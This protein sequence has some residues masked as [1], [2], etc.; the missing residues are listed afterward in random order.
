LG[1]SQGKNSAVTMPAP[2]SVFMKLWL[3]V[4]QTDVFQ[5][6]QLQKPFSVGCNNFP[7]T[8]L[9]IPV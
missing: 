4:K 8:S 9:I 3:G 2:N 6:P 1:Y 7:T 5:I